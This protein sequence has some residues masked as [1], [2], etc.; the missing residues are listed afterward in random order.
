MSELESAD[1][2]IERFDGRAPTYDD[3][4]PHRLI[5][6]AVA[7]FV[8]VNGVAVGRVRDV[9]DA[10]TGTGLVLR[11]LAPLLAPGARLTG[12]DIAPGMLAVA[13][14]K[15]PDATFLR[16]D[17]AALPFGDASFDLLTCVT[18]IHLMPDAAAAIR[19]WARVLRPD[20]RIV[21]ANFTTLSGWGHLESIPDAASATGLAVSRH[22]DLA[23]P[24]GSGFPDVLITELAWP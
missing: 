5:A 23:L 22:A 1:Q 11:A 24:E 17:A 20:G 10:A 3:G 12:I 9:L 4:E 2:L 13:Q 19:E 7:E 8:S 21:I 16:A 6:L 18:G 15:L 14:D